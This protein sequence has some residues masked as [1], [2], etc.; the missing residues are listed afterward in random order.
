MMLLSPAAAELAKA[1]IELDV[2]MDETFVDTASM[3]YLMLR[4]KERGVP[5]RGATTAIIE[6]LFYAGHAGTCAGAS[7]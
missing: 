3:Q 4:C 1:Y 5:I 2:I 7:V 6:G